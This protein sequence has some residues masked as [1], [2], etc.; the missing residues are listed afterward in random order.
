MK[1]GGC[2]CVKLEG[3]KNMADKIAAIVQAGI[4]VVGHIGLTP[5]SVSALGG[6]RLQ[7]A[8]TAA[9]DK[10]VEDAIAVEKAGACAIC[11]E[12]MPSVVS[13]RIT[14]TLKIPTL[15]IGAGPYCDCQ[16]LNLYDMMGLFSDFKP[17]FVKR[18]ANLRNEMVK[19]LDQFYEESASG[20]FP[21]PE[22]SYNA[23]IDGY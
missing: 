22:F 7:G 2:D 5:Q 11:L 15:G 12:C 10:L 9:A 23:Q 8:S 1:E 16:E 19:A 20:E 18:Y 13:K 6:M 17:K 4:P 14:E 21:T 3:G